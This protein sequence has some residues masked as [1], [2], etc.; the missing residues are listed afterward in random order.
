M[1][2]FV[3]EQGCRGR[4]L[5]WNMCKPRKFHLR[6]VLLRILLM[7]FCLH[8]LPAKAAEV[9]FAE[10]ESFGEQAKRIIATL[11][12]S[13]TS[14]LRHPIKSVSCE[15]AGNISGLT[16]LVIA[17]G[18][19]SLDKVL[20]GSG[21]AP[22]IAVFISKTSFESIQAK[23]KSRNNRLVSAIF[24]DPDP[25]R[26]V[27]LVK[28]LYGPSASAVL[29]SSP[30]VQTYMS[31]YLAA[32]ELFDINLK[33]VDLREIKS[34]S[35]FIRATRRA[36]ALFLLKDQELMERVSLE[37]I[38]LSSYDINRQGVIG[39]SRGLVEN[40]GAATTYSSLDNIAHSIYLQSNQ[41][42]DSQSVSPP[43]YTVSFG[44][45]LNKHILRS[46]NIVNMNEDSVQNKITLMIKEGTEK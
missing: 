9:Y 18:P 14:Y 22:V 7:I 35:D 29:V 38:L 25:I 26:Q 28:A 16:N 2:R 1:R 23:Y 30:A 5:I 34:S 39:Y 36:G 27:A 24:S 37:K 17:L 3:G 40:G 8:S 10:P 19:R 42:T 20:S 46:L 33:I 12:L 21:S 41:L 32:A 6:S 15:V 31:G 44:V 43:H 13:T 11:R 45:S 4:L